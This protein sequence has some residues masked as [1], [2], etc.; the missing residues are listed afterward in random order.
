MK[1]SPNTPKSKPKSPVKKQPPNLPPDLM[2]HI[3]QLT[4]QS[5]QL[6][7]TIWLM[8]KEHGGA[9]VVDEAALNPLWDLKYER[10]QVEG[11]DHPSLL[12]ITATQL[13]EPT[14]SQIKLLADE[15]A[16]QPEEKTPEALLK[17]GMAGYPPSFVVARL[18]PIVVC[19]DGKWNRV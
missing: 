6:E 5:L 3:G 16:G 4:M 12:K 18:A 9:M 13:P 15:L 1:S 10:V 19:R 17:A 11:K 2:Q 7:R 8:A 14:D